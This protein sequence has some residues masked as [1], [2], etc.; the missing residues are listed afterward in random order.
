MDSALGDWSDLCHGVLDLR[1]ERTKAAVARLTEEYRVFVRKSVFSLPTSIQVYLGSS[2][3][4]PGVKCLNICYTCNKTYD[5][6]VLCSIIASYSTA[7]H[8]T[9]HHQLVYSV[10]PPPFSRNHHYVSRNMRPIYPIR[11]KQC[12]LYSPPFPRR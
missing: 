11:Y 12:S 2:V 7:Q 5:G 9:N 3:V 10:P 1:E 8:S 4:G 6:L